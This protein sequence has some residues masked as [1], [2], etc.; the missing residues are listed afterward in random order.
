MITYFDVKVEDSDVVETF[1]NIGI[2]Y[3]FMQII[4]KSNWK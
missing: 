3:L 4:H 1:L 2:S